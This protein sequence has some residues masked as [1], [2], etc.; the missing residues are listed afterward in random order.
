MPHPENPLGSATTHRPE[1]DFSIMKELSRQMTL[2]EFAQ[3][4]V[5]PIAI[6]PGN[7][8]L[9]KGCSWQEIWDA[10]GGWGGT[11][12]Y[13]INCSGATSGKIEIEVD[14]VVDPTP[15][16]PGQSRDV[17]GKKIRVHAPTGQTTSS[18]GTYERL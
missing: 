4:V 10:K 7:I 11:K 5:G 14:G 12:D 9:A 2:Y 18:D 13:R 6:S 17:S 3:G 1:I 8:T 16:D 15:L